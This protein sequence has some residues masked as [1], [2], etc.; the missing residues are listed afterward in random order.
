MDEVTRPLTDG[1]RKILEGLRR[2]RPPGSPGLGAFLAFVVTTGVLLIVSPAS[3][4]VGARSLVPVVVALG[5]AG[6]VYR[7]L[8]SSG[9]RSEWLA[10]VDRDLAGGVARVTS[11]RVSDAL[12]VEE[13]EDEGSSYYLELEDG[14]VWFL[15]G[16]Y[17]YELEEDGTFPNTRVTV[18]RA[19]ATGV[20]LA[21]SCDGSPLAP[22][23]TLPVFT[24]QDYDEDRVPEDGAV[25]E[26]DF[27]TLRAS[28]ARGRGRGR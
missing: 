26:V 2:S 17:L 7:R 10:R 23:G 25:V 1:Q 28:A 4:Q 5:V 9:R 11:A 21:V 13:A 8:R 12:R 19:P 14:R 18:V 24:T 27:A 15:T 6:L 3:W 20:V 16:Q 22:R